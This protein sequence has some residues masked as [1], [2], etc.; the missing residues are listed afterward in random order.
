M[1]VVPPK[2]IRAVTR[3]PE[4]LNGPAISKDLACWNWALAAFNANAHPIGELYDYVNGWQPNLPAWVPGPVIPVLQGIRADYAGF[5]GQAYSEPKRV[6]MERNSRAMLSALC[7]IYGLPVSAD[8]TDVEVG[9]KFEDWSPQKPREIQQNH[10]ERLDSLGIGYE[11]MWLRFKK[12]TTVET[13]VNRGALLL[14][15]QEQDHVHEKVVRIFVS[16]VLANHIAMLG[17]LLRVRKAAPMFIHP[18]VRQPWDPDSAADRCTWC[19]ASFSMLTRRHHCRACGHIFCDDCTS[20][21]EMVASP[22]TRPGS[23]ATNNTVERVCDTCFTG[24][25]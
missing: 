20:Q 14:R 5:P 9:L 21:T 18:A 25:T 17:D 8:E 13:W 2:I 4:P 6:A 3:C 7:G 24:N 16:Q 10:G 23:T 12:K 19:R 22:S 1:P 11:H 15:H